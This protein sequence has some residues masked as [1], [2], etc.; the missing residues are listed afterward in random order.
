MG[1]KKREI[2]SRIEKHRE[3]L[4]RGRLGKQSLFVD[5]RH[6]AFDFQQVS[7]SILMAKSLAPSCSQ[8]LPAYDIV[9]IEAG[10]NGCSPYLYSTPLLPLFY[11][12][13]SMWSKGVVF[14]S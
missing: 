11:F 9:L 4:L 7:L 13:I 6:P 1:H 8:L 12:P 10:H 14:L 3:A 2:E 5:A